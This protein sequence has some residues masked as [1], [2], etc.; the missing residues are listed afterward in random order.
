MFA[1]S[2][3]NLSTHLT[4]VMTM[5]PNFQSPPGNWQTCPSSYHSAMEDETPAPAWQYLCPASVSDAEFHL[6]PFRWSVYSTENRNS[7]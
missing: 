5:L 3:K 1:S 4:A 6:Y 7:K 2:Y